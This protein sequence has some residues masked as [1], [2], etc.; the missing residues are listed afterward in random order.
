MK[1]STVISA[2]AR[3]SSSRLATARRRE[4]RE[5]RHHERADRGHRVV[6]DHDLGR[7]R[8]EQRDRVAAA[9]AERLQ[10]LGAAR[11]LARQ[12]RVGERA[13]AALLVLADDRLDA[14]VRGVVGPALDARVARLSRPP[15]EPARP[16]RPVRDVEH[17]L[18]RRLERD[19]EVARDR[20]PEALGLGR[21]ERQQL[22]GSRR[23]RASARA[24]SRG[25][26]RPT[27]PA[28]SRRT[29]SCLDRTQLPRGAQRHLRR[30]RAP[31]RA[32][33]ARRSV[34]SGRLQRDLGAGQHADQRAGRR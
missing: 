32:A 22:V 18:V 24:P 1:A 2:T 7:H 28:G 12:L 8:H 33:N 10:A 26:S 30:R 9:H 16:F 34:V 21:R 19:P 27:P 17:A 3:E 14:G 20:V 13:G 25:R 6:R 29:R 5:D 15:H 31:G 4:A 23:R 11:D